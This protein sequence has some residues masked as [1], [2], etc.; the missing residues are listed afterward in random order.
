MAYL[1]VNG[2]I[3]SEIELGTAVEGLNRVDVDTYEANCPAKK[4]S[5]PLETLVEQ[6]PSQKGGAE[7][8]NRA[9]QAGN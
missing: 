1:Q 2:E 3:R 9:K 7:I 6:K 5:R 8:L 4:S